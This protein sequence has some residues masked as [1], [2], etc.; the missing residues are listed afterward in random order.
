MVTWSSKNPRNH[1]KLWTP[2]TICRNKN[3]MRRK[4]K[5]LTRFWSW[6]M[7]ATCSIRSSH[8][9]GKG[10]ES[11]AQGPSLVLEERLVCV[12]EFVYV[13]VWVC[14]CVCVCVYVCVIVNVFSSFQCRS[15]C[16]VF[17]YVQWFHTPPT[18]RNIFIQIL[19]AVVYLHDNNV[20]HRDLK[21]ENVLLQ[22]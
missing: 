5:Y 19:T 13:W 9:R 17:V 2:T 20:V 11:P 3:T 1:I 7:G 10:M 14:V 12:R 6:C 8:S 16:C 15:Y 18:H 21:P 4:L 22:V